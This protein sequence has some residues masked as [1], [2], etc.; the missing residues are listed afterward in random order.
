M[1]FTRT[2]F[3]LALLSS[4]AAADPVSWSKSTMATAPSYFPSGSTAMVVGVGTDAQP[5]A[6]ALLGALQSSDAFELVTD[7]RAL[8]KVDELSDDDIVK[9]AFARP[10]KRVAIVRVFPAGASVKAVVTVY[11]AQGQVST[12]FTLVPGKNLVE[13]PTP[14]QATD[15][16]ARDEMQSITT[17]T[18]GKGTSSSDGDITYTR[19]QVGM[20]TG[21]GLFTLENVSFFKNGHQISDTPELYEALGMGQQADEFRDKEASHH[22]WALAGGWMTLIG[23][24]SALIFGSVALF[25]SATDY[26]SQTGKAMPSDHTVSWELA[27]GGA[28]MTALGIVLFATHPAPTKLS[29]D[30][31]VALVDAHNKKK[32]AT[33]TQLR[34]APSASPQTAGLVLV[35][36][37]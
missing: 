27:L 37:F 31:A 2:L 17:A 12:A 14:T 6:A 10:I 35:G 19:S 4:P 21:Y 13:N 28:G 22:K 15:G 18:D 8:G 9:R 26:D 30:E 32:Q 7:A 24:T 3:I 33:T 25:S 16:V 1:S 23:G 29:T 11:G 34:L 36:S 5:V 20:V